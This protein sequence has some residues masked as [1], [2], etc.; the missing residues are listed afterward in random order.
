MAWEMA[1]DE[2]AG[3]DFFVRQTERTAAGMT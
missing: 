1:D 2:G 3:N